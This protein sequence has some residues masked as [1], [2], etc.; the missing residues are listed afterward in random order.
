[1]DSANGEVVWRRY[2][3]HLKPFPNGRILLYVLRSSAHLPL[4]PLVA[5]VG[6]SDGS[7]NG[8]TLVKLNPITGE[9]VEERP[10]CLPYHVAQAVLLPITDS[11]HQRVLLLLSDDGVPHC[12]SDKCSSLL[13]QY[14]SDAFLFT[15]DLSSGLLT[16]LQISGS[17]D[18][19][20]V[21]HL[22]SV[23]VM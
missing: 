10:S 18:D 12:Y 4:P 9:V 21:G 19:N 22:T 23:S 8:S 11:T 17:A 3:P 16:G 7:C 13:S 2:L 20:T 6:A 15:A 5:A 14:S 1:M